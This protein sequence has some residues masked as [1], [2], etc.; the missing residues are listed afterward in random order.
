[1]QLAL[2][3]TLRFFFFRALRF[4]GILTIYIYKSKFKEDSDKDPIKESQELQRKLQ[5]PNYSKEIY[6]D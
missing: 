1:M 6:L 5:K 3:T 2:L 4:L